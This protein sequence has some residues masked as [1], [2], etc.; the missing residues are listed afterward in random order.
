MD[1]YLL[2]AYLADLKS[3]CFSVC[4][5]S[6]LI[7]TKKQTKKKTLHLRKGRQKSSIVTIVDKIILPIAHQ[8]TEVIS[9]RYNRLH[10]LHRKNKAS[11][12]SDTRLNGRYELIQKYTLFEGHQRALLQQGKIKK[13][14]SFPL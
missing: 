7:E 3:S 6:F 10:Q 2:N 14:E 11:K 12:I 4:L 1:K 5:R 9:Q 8:L 13:I